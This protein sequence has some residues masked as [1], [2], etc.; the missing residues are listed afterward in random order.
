MTPEETLARVTKALEESVS[1][2]GL[3]NN[4]PP[5]I[6]DECLAIIHGEACEECGDYPRG[7]RGR[8]NHYVHC[9][10]YQR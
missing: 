3:D 10:K 1:I 9:S 6:V 2:H 4:N 8:Q 7:W 5:E